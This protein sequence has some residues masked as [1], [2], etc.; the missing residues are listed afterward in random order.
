[1]RARSS[2]R[3]NGRVEGAE[4]K[5]AFEVAIMWEWIFGGW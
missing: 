2:E 4:G 3:S 5:P 1:V